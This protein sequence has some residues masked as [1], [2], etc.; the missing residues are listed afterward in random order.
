MLREDRS[1]AVV[2]RHLVPIAM[3]IAALTL[4]TLL[5]LAACRATDTGTEA[6]TVRYLVAQGEYKDALRQAH[7]AW[8]LAPDDAAAD[9]DYRFASVALLLERGRRATFEDHD[10]QALKDFE[11]ALELAPDSH[12]AQSWVYKTRTKLSDRWYRLARDR[13]AS[14]RLFDA[15]D[16]YEKALDYDSDNMDALQ[17]LYRVGMQLAHREGLAKDYYNEGLEALRDVKLEIARSRFD[18]AD[19]YS[20]EEDSRGE[21]R[22]AKRRREVDTALAQ[23]FVASA[24]D[25]EEQGYFAAARGE[26]RIA[27]TRDP[28]NRAA[29]EGYARMQN[30][31][32]VLEVY[33]AGEMA[34]RRGEFD[35]AVEILQAGRSQTA[36]Q[37][38]RFDELLGEIDDLRTKAAYEQGLNYEHDFRLN[39][40]AQVYRDILAERDFYEDVRARLTSVEELIA[41]VEELYASLDGLEGEELEATLT[42]IEL[43]W[44]EYRDVEQRLESLRAER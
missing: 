28:D 24:L 9:E 7:E 13:H 32:Q 15:A 10:E 17:G 18:Y 29:K 33:K 42:K 36:V 44:P 6:H 43:L 3:K 31:A 5:P 4:L 1:E 40:A 8:L 20:T 37:Q 41:Q 27:L 11:Q 39:E 14:D 38:D 21:S 2:S 23:R 35:N 26:Y 16:A 19:K 34:I 22:A 25:L 12:E 30:E